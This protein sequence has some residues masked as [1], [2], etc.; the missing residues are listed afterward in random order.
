[1]MK[2]MWI[3]VVAVALTISMGACS[4]KKGPESAAKAPNTPAAKADTQKA[5]E[6][7]TAA[8]KDG[9]T[10]VK[11]GACT[12]IENRQ[13]VG[14]AAVFPPNV[15]RLYL[16]SNLRSV[17]PEP[18][19]ILHVWNFNGKKMASV[20]LPIKGATWRTYSSKTIDPSWL[21]EWRVDLAT[22]KG[23]VIKSVTFRVEQK[24]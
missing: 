10:V 13:P 2:S 20:T 12:S 24:K 22:P 1:M 18:T 17:S 21:G 7:T 6:D 9:I 23:E 16:Y 8:T 11:A 5:V 15:G 3:F 4:G 14:E 19:S